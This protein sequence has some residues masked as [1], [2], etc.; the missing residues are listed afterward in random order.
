MYIFLTLVTQWN[1]TIQW[2]KDQR[3]GEKLYH[4]I[5]PTED[6]TVDK[7]RYGKAPPCPGVCCYCT[8]WADLL[9]V[10]VGAA[11][12]DTFLYSVG[13]LCLSCHNSCFGRDHS[14]P[15]KPSCSRKWDRQE[16][17]GREMRGG[18]GSGEYGREG[19][20]EG[21]C[22]RAKRRQGIKSDE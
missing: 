4:I 11:C 2:H 21:V 16:Q 6:S 14:A 12:Y 10:G 5:H 7:T 20:R 19:G 17:A 18:E 8:G 1:F 13:A 15:A 9:L 22:R 3:L